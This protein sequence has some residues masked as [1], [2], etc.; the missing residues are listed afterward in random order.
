MMKSFIQQFTIETVDSI[1]RLELLF[2]HDI[3]V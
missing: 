2:E 1:L 3:R